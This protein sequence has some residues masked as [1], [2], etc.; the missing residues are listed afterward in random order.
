MIGNHLQ[1]K[2]GVSVV[3]DNKS[4]AGGVVGTM[5]VVRAAPDGHTV[6]MGKIGP[7]SIAWSLYSNLQCRPSSLIPVSN[8]LATPNT[9]VVRPSVPA[10]TVPEKAVIEKE[11]LQLRVN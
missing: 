1:Q 5:E 9:L 4:G 2:W 3:I 11:G 6:L 7:Q 10:R 8:V